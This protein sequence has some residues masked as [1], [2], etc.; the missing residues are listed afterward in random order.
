MAKNS[1]LKQRGSDRSK[2]ELYQALEAALNAVNALRLEIKR[3]GFSLPTTQHHSMTP[4]QKLLEAQTHEEFKEAA[5]AHS[6]LNR[7]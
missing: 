4:A 2:E 1:F 3:R 6:A 7:P 5:D